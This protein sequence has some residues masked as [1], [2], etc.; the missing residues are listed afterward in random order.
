M[1]VRCVKMI[2]IRQKDGSRRGVDESNGDLTREEKMSDFEV[3][4][5]GHDWIVGEEQLVM[6]KVKVRGAVLS[7]QWCWHN[8]QGAIGDGEVLDRIVRLQ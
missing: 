6:L 2:G 8:G 5:I 7:R 3:A 4:S 1:I